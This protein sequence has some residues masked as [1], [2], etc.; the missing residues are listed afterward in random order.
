MSN[1]HYT[2]QT[3]YTYNIVALYIF[4]LIFFISFPSLLQ[5]HLSL[6]SFTLICNASFAGS[7]SFT[8]VFTSLTSHRR[9]S[10]TVRMDMR[11]AL[12]HRSLNRSRLSFFNDDSVVVIRTDS[13]RCEGEVGV[14]GGMR[15]KWR[16]PTMQ[17]KSVDGVKSLVVVNE[18][19]GRR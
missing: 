2:I 14:S 19:K 10:L 8:G 11:S 15:K 13:R 16:S 12:F 18:V 7:L 4:F 9:R 3:S 6:S 17:G 5:H 1:Y